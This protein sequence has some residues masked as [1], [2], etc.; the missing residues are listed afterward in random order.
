M[1][2]EGCFGDRTVLECFFETERFSPFSPFEVCVVVRADI[3]L[4]L[5][6]RVALL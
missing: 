4:I 3:L 5:V 1:A 2:W 6:H